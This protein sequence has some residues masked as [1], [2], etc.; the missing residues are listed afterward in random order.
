MLTREGPVQGG[1]VGAAVG[2]RMVATELAQRLAQPIR[3]ILLQSQA[4][5]QDRSAFDPATAKRRFFV[6]VSDYE[7]PCLCLCSRTMHIATLHEGLARI[8]ARRFPL[9]I[10]PHPADIPPTPIIA[11]WNSV[12]ELDPGVRWF[13]QQMSEVARIMTDV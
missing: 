10:F 4:V 2:G 1:G 5:I 9:K 13:L 3:D 11:Q 6:A 12:R 8:F 7:A